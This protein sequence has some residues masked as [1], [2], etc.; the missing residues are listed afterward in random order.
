MGEICIYLAIVVVLAAIF[1]TAAPRRQREGFVSARA[2]EVYQVS[3][4][5]FEGGTATYSEYKDILDGA[6]PVLHADTHRLW[7]AGRLT[8]EAVEQIL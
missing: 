3:R 6:D 4:A 1:I 7:K 8:P 2:R 5:A